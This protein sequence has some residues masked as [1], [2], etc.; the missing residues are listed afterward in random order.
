[1]GIV[2]DTINIK[3]SRNTYKYYE[4]L[5]YE[6]PKKLD[7]RNK[8]V[9]DESKY[10]TVKI[11]DLQ[12]GS[13]VK[14]L[15]KCDNPYCNSIYEVV[16]KDYIN[17]NHN[18]KTYCNHCSS[19]V[20]ISGENNPNYGGKY[21]KTGKDSPNWNPNKTQEERELGRNYRQYNYFIKKVLKRDNY[22]CQCCGQYKGNI[23][24]HHLDGY[25]WCKEK[26]TDETNGIC[27]CHNCHYNFHSIYG[28]GNNTKEQFE[29][30]IGKVVELLK[31]EGELP[32]ARKVYCIEE[33]KVYNSI[34]EL[35]KEWKLKGETLAYY[36]CNGKY[37]TIKD[38]H[39]LWYDSYI[40][41]SKKEIDDFVLNN[42]PI[43][44]RKVICITTNKLFDT[45]KKASKFYNIDNSSITKCCKYKQKTAG[46]LEDG[47]R[48]KWM[49]YEDYIEQNELKEKSC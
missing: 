7:Y 36:V 49:Y 8:P 24:V 13:K 42:T 9:A 6:I 29:E 2:H 23:E 32:I 17:H 39:L 41:M 44:K 35:S 4:N 18:G 25:D 20:L 48:L 28:Y 43:K 40:K 45:I 27:L 33:N 31:Y 1:M 10:I 38:K 3:I 34:K 14:V 5:G 26:R 19:K 21:S 12:K 11:K 47:T 16:Y 46:K 22:T 37:K 15:V 30:W